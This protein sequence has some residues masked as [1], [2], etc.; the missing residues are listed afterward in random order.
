MNFLVTT[1]G[2][3]PTVTFID[4]GERS[5]THP[6]VDVDFSLEYSFQDLIDSA[7]LQAAID[8]GEVTVT[9][10]NGNSISD[11]AGQLTTQLTIQKDDADVST[12]ADTLNF[13]GA[14]VSVADE[15][16]GKATVTIPDT[17]YTHPNHTGDVTSVGDGA[18]TIQPD[19]VDNTKLAN[20]SG[21]TLKG[22]DT[23]SPADPQDLTPTEVRTLLD[24]YT[25]TQVD[26]LVDA[27]LKVPEAYDP[28]GSGNF[29]TTYDGNAVTKGDTFRIVTADTLGTGTVVNP[30]DLLIALVDT[31]AQVDANWQVV[32]SNRDQATETV[33]GVAEIAT[34]AEVNT[35]TDDQ[36]IITPAK[37]AGSTLASDVATNN[38]KV[39]NATHTG[40]VTGDT[41]LTISADVVDNTKLSN[42]PAFTIKGNDTAGVA[43]PQDLTAAE[44]R[45]LLN[46]ADGA[47]NYVHPNH[48]GDITSVGDGVTTISNNAVTNTKL[49][50]M[51]ALTIKGNDTVASADPQD[52]T[53]AEVRI[54]LNVADGAN[55]YTHPNHTG[56][57]SSVGDGVTTISNDAVSNAKLA[58]MAT[59]RLK[60]RATAGSGDPEDLQISALTEE[61]TPTAGDWL[62]GEDAAGSLIK[63]NVG[64]LPGGGGGV[65][66]VTGGVNITNSGTAADPILDHDAH[67]GDVTGATALTIAADVV[68][69]TKLA[70]MATNRLKGRATAGVGDPEDLQISALT[71]ELTPTSGDWL[72]GEDALGNLI[73]INVGNLPGGGGGA[74][75]SVTGGV[76]I[77]NSGTAAD[78]ILDHDAHTGDVTGATALT[79]AADAVTNTKLA[80]MPAN[81]FKAN[82][83]A[84]FGDPV[85][86]TVS[87]DTI[88]GRLTGGNIAALTPTQVRTLLNVEDGANNYIHPNHTGDVVSLGDGTTF[89]S[90]D[91]V[92]NAKLAEMPANTLKGNDTAGSANPQDLSPTEVRT[93]LNVADGANNYVH[94]NHS[95]DVTSVADGATTIQPNVVTNAKLADMASGTIKARATA[96]S[97]DPEDILISGLTEE[98]TPASGDWLLGEDSVG[99]LIKIDPTNLPSSGGVATDPIWDVQGD[100]VVATGPDAA[101]RIPIGSAGSFLRSDSITAAWSTVTF[102]NA[103]NAGD[104]LYAS[105]LNNYDNLAAGANTEVL[106]IVGGV[107]TWQAPNNYVHPNHTGDVTS[108]GDGAQT[109]QPDVVDNTKLANMPALTIKGNDTGVAADPQDLTAAEVRTL[110]NVADGANNYVHPNHSGDV[111]SVAD[112]ATTIQPDVVDNTKLANMPANTF[113]GNNTGVSAD[114]QDLSIEDMQ[115]ALGIVDLSDLA[116]INARSQENMVVLRNTNGT[117]G[118][119]TDITTPLLDG[120]AGAQPLF[121]TGAI[122]NALYVGADEFPNAIGYVLSTAMVLGAGTVDL[123]YW[124]GTAWSTLA[125]MESDASNLISNGDSY[126]ESVG[127]FHLRNNEPGDAALLTLD[128]NNK[129]WIRCIVTAAI[130]TVPVADNLNWFTDGI[131]N[132]EY[133]GDY[134]RLAILNVYEF[135]DVS[136][137]LVGNTDVPA[138]PNTGIN[139]QNNLLN[140]NA[141]DSFG[142][143]VRVPEDINTA[144]HIT[145]VLSYI[146]DSTNVNNWEGRMALAI[147]QDGAV[148][149]GTLPEQTTSTVIPLDGTANLVKRYQETFDLEASAL[150]D[151]LQFAIGRDAT[152]GNLND[153]YTGG[154]AARVFS[155]AYKRWK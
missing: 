131:Y 144:K 38:A 43:D 93:L 73:K 91:A 71:E 139:K 135:Q 138:G 44:V 114:P 53:A 84:V 124:D 11:I 153:L 55:N 34:Q 128:G 134:Q 61:L 76:N 98:L 72:L 9:D 3:V 36:R 119:W 121:D 19:V 21:S 65:N 94:P 5:L 92:N 127:T 145:T 97:G 140:N 27:S 96:G 87:E 64:N 112:G 143:I 25:T 80:N 48:S 15:G 110:L 47:N 51:P 111:T 41:A 16:G 100:L 113:K 70:N 85:D 24:V 23:G 146:P 77:T 141:Y 68:D 132:T 109:I 108:V 154:I 2:T 86:V 10:G 78:P 18:T 101:T 12:P 107:P 74:V 82:N 122:N 33:K 133:F 118:T 13:E 37:L 75:N 79:I 137:R 149:D 57:V 22:N 117:V 69:N 102:P 88:V 32:E 42:M 35:G 46:I 90:N 60:G 49:S 45:T 7:D 29:P 56:D 28:A 120:G 126:F 8:A 58:D 31:P 52:L 62:L 20:M 40:D 6:E 104:I 142:V 39:S 116:L 50:D 103:A 83:T 147:V 14:G 67:T 136:S 148:A 105:G 89:I 115:D 129:Y 26:A 130:T 66:S 152:G 99:N 106:T 81:S 54:L 17:S 30:E 150:G 1:T 151:D 59:N 123:Q 63:V 155:I 125:K 95:G 4:L